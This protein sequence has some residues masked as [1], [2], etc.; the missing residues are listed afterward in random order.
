V[1]IRAKS[2]SVTDHGHHQGRLLAAADDQ[3][4]P[5]GPHLGHD[6]LG[7][8]GIEWII[9]TDGLGQNRRE[10]P[11]EQFEEDRFLAPEIEIEGAL[12]DTSVADDVGD[13]AGPARRRPEG[14]LPADRPS[15]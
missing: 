4:A 10:E 8:G 6:L 15:W 1:E 3:G 13:P 2:R 7:R 11:V 9:G 14:P 5:H 12:R